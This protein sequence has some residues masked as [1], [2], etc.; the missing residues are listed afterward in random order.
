MKQPSDRMLRLLLK[1]HG[2][3]AVTTML[4]KRGYEAVPYEL[5]NMRAA[6][7]ATG[8]ARPLGRVVDDSEAA[9]KLRA[10]KDSGSRGLLRL[11]LITGQH[12]IR[13]PQRVASL[14]QDL[15]A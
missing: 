5:R 2:A 7:V 4:R 6:M 8:E 9:Q 3:K 13:D 1:N 14:L 15:A 11:Q 10:D 12:S